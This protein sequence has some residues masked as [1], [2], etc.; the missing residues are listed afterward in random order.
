M[1]WIGKMLAWIWAGKQTAALDWCR[2]GTLLDPKE[3][4][5]GQQKMQLLPSEKVLAHS[6]TLHLAD[7]TVQMLFMVGQAESTVSKDD[8]IYR[9]C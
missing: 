2:Q 8:V 1:S 3:A 7:E 6:N 4:V 5:D 9:Q